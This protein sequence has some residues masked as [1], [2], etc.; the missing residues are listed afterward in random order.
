MASTITVDNLRLTPGVGSITAR[1]D[2]DL[3]TV[4]GKWPYVQLDKVE[5][6]YSLVNDRDAGTSFIDGAEEATLTG[7][8]EGEVYYWWCRARDAEPDDPQYSDWYPSGATD[9]VRGTVGFGS[10][11]TAL[12]NGTIEV[13]TVDNDLY[14]VLK[15]LSGNT[16]S[17]DD[18]VFCGFR[19]EAGSY[20]VLAITE[21]KSAVVPDGATLGVLSGT[22]FRI[23][24]A[25]FSIGGGDVELA[26]SLRTDL[27]TGNIYGL[28][29]FG[30][31]A[32]PK[33]LDVTSGTFGVWYYDDSDEAQHPFRVVGFSDWDSGLATAG[34]WSDDP[35]RTVLFGPGV[36]LAGEEIQSYCNYVR[37]ALVRTGDIPYDDTIPQSSEGT[38][39][40]MNAFL[41]PH[42][43]ANVLQSQYCVR[44]SNSNAASLHNTVALFRDSE[45][46]AIDAAWGK[47]AAAD[48]L[49]TLQG[50]RRVIANTTG[51]TTFSL[52]VGGETAGSSSFTRNGV[53]GSRKFGGVLT[54][55]H[56]LTEFMG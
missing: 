50:E 25:L 52:R 23:W 39:L 6:H 38:D 2:V 16:P 31:I 43:K 1:C 29:E 27:A 28:T 5:F 45:T 54:S 12:M 15:T 20:F 32:A 13:Y 55:H 7:L 22:P 42:A 21:A 33:P 4:I 19:D 44:G 11:T 49:L 53:G 10:A 26:V 48:D 35:D 47:Q 37:S 40:G 30:V 51:N 46:D 24:Y 34:T 56:R 3:S 36:K 18:P 8:T 17:V 14:V 41:R 9:G